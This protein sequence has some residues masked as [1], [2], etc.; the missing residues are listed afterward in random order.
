MGLLDSFE[1][2]IKP[3][4]TLGGICV[5]LGT[6][7]VTGTL[8]YVDFK[9]RIETQSG[10]LKTIDERISRLEARISNVGGVPGERG[11]AGPAGR[12]GDPGPAGERGPPGPPGPKGEAGLSPSQLNEIERRI[13]VLE[14]KPQNTRNETQPAIHVASATGT[15]DFPRNIGGFKRHASGCL[16]VPPNFQPFTTTSKVG[17]RFCNVNGERVTPLSKID[18]SRVYWNGPNCG[19]GDSFCV[20]YWNSSLAVK[21]KK[22]DMAQD[23]QM[24]AVLEWSPR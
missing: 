21:V 7:C 12:P 19:I 1:S 3:L 5:G 17:D 2:H 14:R 9:N 22:I 23:G 8:Y 6:A 10:A 4:V 20:A 15:A 16:F 18:E 13:G 11:V 24:L